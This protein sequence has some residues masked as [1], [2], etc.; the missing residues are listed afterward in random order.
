M[1]LS[2]CCHV[3]VG[4]SCRRPLSESRGT[5]DSLRPTAYCRYPKHPRDATRLT[6]CLRWGGRNRG[7]HAE[8]VGEDDGEGPRSPRE[9]AGRPRSVALLRRG[10]GTWSPAPPRGPRLRRRRTCWRGGRRTPGLAPRPFQALTASPW[11]G[12][13]LCPLVFR[14]PLGHPPQAP[15]P[16]RD[17]AAASPVR[18]ARGPTSDSNIRV[19]SRLREGLGRVSRAGTEHRSSAELPSRIVHRVR[20]EKPVELQVRGGR[21]RRHVLTSVLSVPVAQSRGYVDVDVED[22][23]QFRSMRSRPS[24][25]PRP[26]DGYYPRFLI[27]SIVCQQAGWVGCASLCGPDPRVSP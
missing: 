11:P 16:V 4:F 22:I 18:A 25:R 3:V 27:L 6:T 1:L 15:L 24:H 23:V 21:R 2:C 8:R 17:I 26:V 19:T 7:L 13:R 20:S 9:R 12:R 14:L 10:P 5:P